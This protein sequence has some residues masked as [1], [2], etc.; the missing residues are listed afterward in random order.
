VK[1]TEAQKCDLLNHVDNLLD[2]IAEDFKADS[3]EDGPFGNG[4]GDE[5]Y[6]LILNRLEK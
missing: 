4:F 3:T 2:V 5:L 1:L 6:N